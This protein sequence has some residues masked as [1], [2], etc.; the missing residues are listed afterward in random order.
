MWQSSEPSKPVIC[1]FGKTQKYNI[2]LLF[3]PVKRDLSKNNN[4]NNNPFQIS[5]IYSSFSCILCILFPSFA[6]HLILY[7]NYSAAYSWHCHSN[8][9][10][11]HV[12]IMTYSAYPYERHTDDDDGCRAVV[13][14][15]ADVCVCV[16]VLYIHLLTPHRVQ[17][18]FRTKPKMPFATLQHTPRIK[19]NQMY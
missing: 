2:L 18:I 8:T 7:T 16:C 10:S 4:N 12:Y 6:K 3:L 19:W 5:A 13:V 11:R 9:A 15:M 1:S 14:V 17:Q